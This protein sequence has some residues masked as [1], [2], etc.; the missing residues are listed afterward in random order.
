MIKRKRGTNQSSCLNQVK[1]ALKSSFPLVF[2]P[3][4][5]EVCKVL[6]CGESLAVV[7]VI[8]KKGTPL[9]PIYIVTKQN[10]TFQA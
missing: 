9:A 1:S 4:S 8:G 3:H 7:P 6:N 2:C 5:S 10:P